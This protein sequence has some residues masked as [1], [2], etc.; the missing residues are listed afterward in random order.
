M[1]SIANENKPGWKDFWANTMVEKFNHLVGDA[2]NSK[3]IILD[4]LDAVEAGNSCIQVDE[5]K[6]R[7]LGGLLSETNL[8]KAPF[9]F[10]GDLL[11][12]DHH[13]QLERSLAENVRR[14]INAKSVEL[15]SAE[16]EHLLTDEHQKKSLQVVFKNNFNLI[17]GGPGTG[18]TYTLARI[19]ASLNKVC[20]NPRIAMAAPTGKAAQRMQEALQNAFSNESLVSN[21]LVTDKLKSLVPITIH[22]L[23]GIGFNGKSSF[24]KD[25]KL[26]IDILVVDEVSM[27]DLNIA[28]Q[29]FSAVA[30][31]TRVILLGDPK[32]LASVDVGGI[33]LDLKSSALL[34]NNQVQLMKSVRFGDDTSIGRI[35]KFILEKSDQATAQ[36]SA[37]ANFNGLVNLMDGESAVFDPIQASNTSTCL[38]KLRDGYQQYIQQIKNYRSGSSD[39]DQLVVSFDK[40]RILTATKHGEFGLKHLNSIITDHATQLT[41]QDGEWYL[42]RPVMITQNNYKLG[43][44]NGDIGI[45]VN[46]REN[47][48]EYEVYFQS[49][50]KWIS[51]TRLPKTIE[52]AYV[53]TIHKSQGSEFSRVAVVLDDSEAAS[54]VL[55]MELIYTAITRA[56]NEIH[57]VCGEQALKTSLSVKTTRQ[58]GLQKKLI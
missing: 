9:H 21:G 5:S 57:L 23:L 15:D 50:N 44:S 20:N 8:V 51:T 27:L 53:M 17:T 14:I 35:A 7:D 11:Y 41:N 45:C 38:V 37:Q 36:V 22:R 24:G 26:P 3:K 52:T 32:Q 25:K 10:D 54:R 56:K 48:G 29:L 19:I 4:L 30:D 43:L 39:H 55:S 1:I 2:E 12:M 40:Y 18:K 16:F 42:G 31:G 46:H 49:S 33:L 6:A 34:T 28:A 13:F 47:K 58:S